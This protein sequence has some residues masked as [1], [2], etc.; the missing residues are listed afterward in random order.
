MNDEVAKLAPDFA[1]VELGLKST[2]FERRLP[3]IAKCFR[4]RVARRGE[5]VFSPQLAE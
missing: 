1:R 2:F 5:N 4:R 3:N